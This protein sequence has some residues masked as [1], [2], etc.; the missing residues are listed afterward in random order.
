MSELL[1]ILGPIILSIGTWAAPQPPHSA[2][3]VVIYGGQRLIEANAAFRGYDLGTIPGRCGFSAI[4]PSMLGKLAWFAVDPRGPWHG[5]CA[6]VDA[7]ARH[8]AYESIYVR[9]EVAEVSWAMAEALGFTNGGRW[10]FVYFSACQP[11]EPS[12]GGNILAPSAWIPPAPYAP[13][14]EFSAYGHESF[15]P[16]P[17]LENPGKCVDAAP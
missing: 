6:S 11:P 12:P 9:R 1:G 5:P 7:V 16:Y 2:G 8:H 17:A 15:Y 14:L 10:A 4:S 3:L 13:P